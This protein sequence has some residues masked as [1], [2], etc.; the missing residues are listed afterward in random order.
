[1]ILVGLAVAAA[2]GTGVGL[3][4]HLVVGHLVADEGRLTPRWLTVT[5]SATAAVLG[6]AAARAVRAEP[7]GP[8]LELFA[9]VLFGAVGVAA[10]V[11]HLRPRR[12]H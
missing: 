2:L 6:T 5:I 3:V 12:R 1:V 4:G 7:P 8:V 9:A 10:A 11:Y